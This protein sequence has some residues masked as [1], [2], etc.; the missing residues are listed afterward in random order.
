MLVSQDIAADA[1]VFMVSI[2]HRVDIIGSRL[3]C[4]FWT[5]LRNLLGALSTREKNAND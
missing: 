2:K 1:M 4:L 5:S 3:F